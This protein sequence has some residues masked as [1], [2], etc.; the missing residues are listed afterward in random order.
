MLKA[1]GIYREGALAGKAESDKKI[2]ELTA[3]YIRENGFEV[4]LINPEEI[5]ENDNAE[6]FFSMAR[7]AVNNILKEKDAIF[8]NNPNAIKKALNRGEVYREMIDKGANIPE[9]KFIKREELV[10]SEKKHILK[11]GNRHE[12]WFII[13]NEEDFNNAL[14]EYKQNEIDDIIMQKF[15][16]GEHIK[17]YGI[18]EKIF[19]PSKVNDFEEGVLDD[20]KK[21]VEIARS[22][23]GLDVYGG[24]FIIGE[25]P[26]CVDINDWPSFGSVEGY[27]QEDLAPQI[28]EYII[29]EFNKKN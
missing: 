6:L 13:E 11:P 22:I 15:V 1:I 3:D 20:M 12:F 5:T 14:N 28:G 16:D 9:T 7:G 19:F 4:S 17:F 24:D 18:G 10:F 27:A 23:T 8:F 21:Q 2:L 26:Y 25:K 29:N